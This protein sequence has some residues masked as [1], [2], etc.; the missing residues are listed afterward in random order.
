[1]ERWFPAAADWTPARGETFEAAG[2]SGEVTEVVP[3]HRLAWTYAGQLYGFDLTTDG[4][5]AAWSSPTSSTTMASPRRPPPAGRPTCR[6]SSRISPV[7][8]S[9]KRWRTSRGRSSTSSTPS[10]SGSTRG[11]ADASPRR[12]AGTPPTPDPPHHHCADHAAGSPGSPGPPA[13][14]V[15]SFSGVTVPPGSARSAVARGSHG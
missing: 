2:E 10:A 3:P 5:A 14:A 1:M 12:C 9:R 13:P 11:R 8:S 6:G 7:S 15:P 4:A